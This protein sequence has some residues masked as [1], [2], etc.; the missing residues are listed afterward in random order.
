MFWD[1]GDG[2]VG[3]EGT[4]PFVPGSVGAEGTVPFV[5]GSVGAEGTVP[6]VSGSVGTEGTVPFVPGLSLSDRNSLVRGT[7][8]TV[9]LVPPK[10]VGSWDKRNRPPCPS[11]TNGTVPIVPLVSF[12]NRC[13]NAPWIFSACLFLCTCRP[14]DVLPP[15]SCRNGLLLRSGPTCEMEAAHGE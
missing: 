3:T 7:N 15:P 14:E 13:Y 2:S 10:S 9:P 5:P 11:G 1:R 12:A 6:S 8:G 4:V